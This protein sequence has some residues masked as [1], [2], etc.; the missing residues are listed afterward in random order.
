MSV[1]KKLGKVLTIVPK[2]ID[3]KLEEEIAEK[4]QIAVVTALQTLDKATP[5]L[6]TLLAGGKI[7]ARI[8]IQLVDSDGPSV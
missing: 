1:W 2:K 3:I 6:T 4:T 5:I 8:T 7:E